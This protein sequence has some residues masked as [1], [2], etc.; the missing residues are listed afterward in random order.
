[1][2]EDIRNKFYNSGDPHDMYIGQVVEVLD[3]RRK[4]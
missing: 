2:P 3:Q 4:H 1:M